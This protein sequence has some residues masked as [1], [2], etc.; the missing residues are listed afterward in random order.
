MEAENL[1]FE[2]R[3]LENIDPQPAPRQ[4]V[5]RDVQDENLDSLMDD[6]FKDMGYEFE[7]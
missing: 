4:R 1:P 3:P 5:L 2:T 6:L 7:E